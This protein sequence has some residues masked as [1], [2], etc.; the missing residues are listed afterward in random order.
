MQL[1]KGGSSREIHKLRGGRLEIWQSGFHESRITSWADYQ[2]KRDYVWFDP[3]AKTLVDRPELWANGS[4]SG[5]Y[6]VDPIPQGLKPPG[7]AR[8]GD[9]GPKGPTPGAL[10]AAGRVADGPTPS[11]VTAGNEEVVEKNK[12]LARRGKR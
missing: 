4:A 3:V 6:A 12:Q 8:G 2:R 11:A 7:V 10:P 5:K 1:I 9:V